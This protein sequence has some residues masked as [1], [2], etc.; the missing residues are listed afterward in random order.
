MVFFIPCDACFLLSTTCVH[1]LATC[2]SHNNF[3]ASCCTWLRFLI[4]STHHSTSQLVHLCDQPICG[5]RQLFHLKQYLLSLIFIL[6]PWVLFAQGFQFIFVHCLL[7]FFLWVVSSCA[8]FGLLLLM[9][10]FLSLI[11]I[12]RVFLLFE[13]PYSILSSNVSQP[14]IYEIK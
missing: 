9:D 7:L 5:G 8:L 14:S 4:S 12:Y 1:S 2:T 11:F 10:G 3:L 6:Q 13:E